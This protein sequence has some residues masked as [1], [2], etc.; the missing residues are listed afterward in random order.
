MKDSAVMNCVIRTLILLLV[1]GLVGCASSPPPVI[2]ATN[3][4]IKSVTFDG[5]NEV[6]SGALIDHIYAGESRWIPLTPDYP[7]DEALLAADVVRIEEYYAARGYHDARV[8]DV[9]TTVDDKKRKVAVHFVINEGDPTRVSTVRFEWREQQDAALVRKVEESALLADGDVF[10]VADYNGTLG[11]LRA[12]LLNSG[13]PL[14]DV[15]GD[16]AVDRL[17]RTADVRFVVTP[18]PYAK[19]AKIQIEGLHRVPEYLVQREVE[20]V[21]GK[22]YSPAEIVQIEGAVKAMQVFRW[23]AASPATDVQDGELTVVL[24]VSESDPHAIRFGLE[25]GIDTV[26]WQQ[27]G[28]AE[29]TNTN[30]FGHLTRLDLLVK[31]GWAELP[32]PFQTELDGPVAVVRPKF[33]KKGLLE[34]HLVWSLAPQAGFDLREGY[35]YGYAGERLAVSRWFAGRYRAAVAQEFKHVNFF[36]ISPDLD[37]NSSILG[38]D[39][40]DPYELST[41]ALRLQAY[42]TNSI[43]EPTDGVILESHYTLSAGAIAS[44]FDFHRYVLGARGYWRPWRRLQFAVKTEGGIIVGFGDNPSS[45]FDRRFYLGGSNSVRGWGSRRLAPRLECA[46]EDTDCED[47]PVGG[48]S[49]LRGVFETRWN[50]AGPVTLVGFFDMGD[51]QRDELT[52]LPELWNYSAGPG[53]RVRSPLGIVRTDLGLRLNDTGVYDEASWAIYFGLGDT[54]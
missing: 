40:R 15:R 17:A 7:Y 18:G 35:Q 31:A 32:N 38:R 34:R 52:F 54:L 10:D 21:L 11:A 12:K 45:P 4:L 23:V 51:V 41:V 46:P 48:Y 28:R 14:A 13:F 50:I 33:S 29:Y 2:G 5:A 22:Q 6:S 36:N 39:F 25:L 9:R 8:V 19:I 42:W 27:N 30:L 47:V 37:A 24:R 20:F 26:R 1:A 3:Y 49:M 53:L 44:D 43:T 16:A